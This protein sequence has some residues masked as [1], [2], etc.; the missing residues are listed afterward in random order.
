MIEDVKNASIYDLTEKISKLPEFNEKTIDTYLT[1]KEFADRL[2]QIIYL[3]NRETDIFDIPKLDTSLEGFQKISKVVTEFTP[4]INNYNE[5][6]STSKKVRRDEPETLD[7]F[8][9]ASGKLG[10]EVGIITCAAYYKVAYKSVG[11]IYRASGLNRLAFTCPTCIKIILSD[12]HWFIRN[13]LV[14]E[15]SKRIFPIF[16]EVKKWVETD[17]DEIPAA[18]EEKYEE[19]KEWLNQLNITID[20]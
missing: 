10:I 13:T 20:N 16:E 19:V 1:Y 18:A 6:I 12:A 9:V 4:L 17:L 5:V 7:D 2:N 15:S 11:I 14:E 3:L 8:Y